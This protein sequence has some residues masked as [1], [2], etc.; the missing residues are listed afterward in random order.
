MPIKIRISKIIPILYDVF[1]SFPAVSMENTSHGLM[2]SEW[3]AEEM[4]EVHTSLSEGS[5][6]L[7]PN[8]HVFPSYEKL[9]V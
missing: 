4:Q 6:Q 7:F 5:V 1:G 2:R 8:I 3:I 9:S